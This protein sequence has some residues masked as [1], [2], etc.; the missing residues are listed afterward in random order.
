MVGAGI[1]LVVSFSIDA[2]RHH[3]TDSDKYSR[4][5]GNTEK[6]R[7]YD[8]YRSDHSGGGYKEG[9]ILTYG[10]TEG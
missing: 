7:R 3:E 10:D 6:R 2:Q 5:V 9:G 4:T 8:E 1:D